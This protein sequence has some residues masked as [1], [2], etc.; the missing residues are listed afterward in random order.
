MKP[1]NDAVWNEQRE[2]AILPVFKTGRPVFGDSDGVLRYVDGDCEP[3]VGDAGLSKTGLAP[4]KRPWWSVWQREVIL[5]NVEKDPYYV[6]Y[7]MRCRGL[8]RMRIVE[9]N[10]WRCA[11]GAPCDYRQV[12]TDQEG[13]P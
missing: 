9:R 13:P 1:M 8:I 2:R 10:C 4:V 7:C 11:C 5:R 3:V 12:L 6:P